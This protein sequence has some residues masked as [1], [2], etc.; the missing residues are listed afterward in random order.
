M[1]K[2]SPGGLGQL[3]NLRQGLSHLSVLPDPAMR[4]LHLQ[5]DS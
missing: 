1:K 4:I 3:W 2:K 5:Y